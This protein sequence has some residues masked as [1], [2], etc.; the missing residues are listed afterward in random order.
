MSERHP[1]CATSSLLSACDGLEHGFFGRRGGVSSGPYESLNAG[2]GSD[3]DGAAVLENRRRICATVGGAALAT[4]YQIHSAIAHYAG[5]DFDS[6]NPPRCDALVTDQPGLVVGIVTSDCAPVLLVDPMAGIVAACHAGWRGAVSGI[7]A[8]TVSEMEKHGARSDRIIAAIG[9]AI[10][11][12]SYEVG[13]EVRQAF[14]A[15]DPFFANFFAKGVRAG[16]FQF[17][18]EGAVAGQLARAGVSQV[19][20]LGIDTYCDKNA[21]FSYR[22]S[23]HEGATDYG[24]QLSVITLAQT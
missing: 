7:V 21:Y 9:P 10:A 24:R 13:D 12:A 5:A 3:D 19:E 20:P 22:R 17:D 15:V 11:Q 6:A 8:A 1:P 23:T 16:A 2:R 4:P 14:Q 18:L